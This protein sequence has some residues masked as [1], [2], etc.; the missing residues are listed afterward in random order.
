MSLH[1]DVVTFINNFLALK[2]NAF[3]IGKKSHK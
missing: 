1:R 3:S 2:T